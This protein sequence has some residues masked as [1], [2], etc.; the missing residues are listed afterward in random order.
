MK[1]GYFDEIESTIE[2]NPDS[3]DLFNIL[4]MAAMVIFLLAGY[5]FISRSPSSLITVELMSAQI[6]REIYVLFVYMNLYSL[7]DNTSV[8]EK[9]WRRLV[10]A[11]LTLCPDPVDFSCA[12]ISILKI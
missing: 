5:M 3:Y 1:Y 6:R 9:D 7:S 4:N 2:F 12:S 11:T 10:P 8:E